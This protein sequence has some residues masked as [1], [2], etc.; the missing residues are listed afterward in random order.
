MCDDVYLMQSL[1]TQFLMSF[2]IA[3]SALPRA[4]NKRMYM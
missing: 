3:N 4:T 2:R 1:H